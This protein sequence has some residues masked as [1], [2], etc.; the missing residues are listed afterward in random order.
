MNARR[1]ETREAFYDDADQ[2]EYVLRDGA[3]MHW[4][5]WCTEDGDWYGVRA[6]HEDDK[7]RE[8]DPHRPIGPT[9]L[10]LIAL[11]WTALPTEALVP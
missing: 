2:P 11:P 4:L 6:A 3:Y 10:D 8:S 9:P 5:I 7:P 1:Y